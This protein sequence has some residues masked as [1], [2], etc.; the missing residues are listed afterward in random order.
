V[1]HCHRLT[2]EETLKSM[3]L[4]ALKRIHQA[5]EDA[6]ILGNLP[7][8]VI[9]HDVI[10]PSNSISRDE[11][12]RRLMRDANMKAT[13]SEEIGLIELREHQEIRREFFARHPELFDAEW[14]P[15][16]KRPF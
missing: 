2:S 8:E 15:R 3:H 12:I 11:Y 14:D 16:K 5:Y 9:N 13:F 10:D 7:L 4:E 6:Y 1:A